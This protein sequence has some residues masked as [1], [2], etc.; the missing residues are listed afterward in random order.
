VKPGL[1]VPKLPRKTLI[2]LHESYRF[3]HSS[4]TAKTKISSREQARR[5][6]SVDANEEKIPEPF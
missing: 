4:A 1:V 2:E 3:R 5:T 6:R